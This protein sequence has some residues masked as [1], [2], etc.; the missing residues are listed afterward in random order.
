M[1]NIDWLS[2]ILKMITVTGQLEAR[3]NRVHHLYRRET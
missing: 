3:L 2:H 1:F